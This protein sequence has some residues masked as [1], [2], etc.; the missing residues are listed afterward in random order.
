ML[1]VAVELIGGDALQPWLD[2]RP[3]RRTLLQQI[4][5]HHRL[6]TAQALAELCAHNSSVL[7]QTKGFVV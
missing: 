2:E 1:L 4:A 7:L 6:I 5:P 3:E